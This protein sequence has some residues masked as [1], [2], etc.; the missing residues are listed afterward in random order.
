[1]NLVHRFAINI[2]VVMVGLGAASASRAQDLYDT[3]V[4]RTFDISFH[5]ADWLARLR[6]NYVSQTYILA[7][8][9]VDGTLYE[10]VG[11]RIR[12]NTSYTALPPGSQ[13]FS[14]KIKMDQVIV[15]QELMGYDTINLNNGFRDPTFTREVVYNNFVARFIPNP[16]ASHAVVT[17]NGENWGVYINVQQGDKRMLRNYFVDED[18]LRISCANNPNG[19]G[20]AYNGPGA[21]GYI[22][23]EIQS[24]GGL[25]NPLATLIALTNLLSNEPLISWPNIDTQFA[26]DPAIWS[27]VLENLLTDDDSYINKGC[28]FTAYRDPI[29]GRTHLLQRDANETFTQSTWSPTRNFNLAN[30]PVLSRVLAVP[31]LRQ[32]YFAHYR[33]AMAELSWTNFASIFAA[34]RDLIDAAVQA[35]TK[36]LYSHA[37]FQNNFSATVTLPYSG[38]AGGSLVGIEQ[39]V[40][41]RATFLAGITELAASGPSLS[42]AQALPENPRPIDAVWVTIAAA[43]NGS[44]VAAVELFYRPAPTA[45]YLRVPMLDDGISGD[46]IAGDGV[47]GVRL[48]VAA[49]PGQRV[50][51]YVG[52]TA[53]NASLSSSFMPA[54]AERGPAV[55]EYGLNASD[56]LR[57][58]EWMYAGGNGEFVELSNLSDEPINLAGWSIDDDHALPGAFPLDAAGVLQPGASVVVTDSAAEVFRA[59]WSLAADTP[60]VGL[61]GATQGNSLGRSDQINV[62]DAEGL[63]HDRLTYGDQTFTG[64]I[65]T[66]NTSGQAACSV[67]GLDAVADWQLSA[68]GDEFGSIASAAADVGTPGRVRTSD[69]GG[70]FARIFADGFE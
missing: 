25:E 52:S 62:F 70:F 56:G 41:A 2:I 40:N 59:A 53:A 69:C 63:L 8:L 37:L 39:F 17:L 28:D 29:D 47:F 12:G 6:A 68:V 18:G 15:D 60:I 48:P 34:H 38:L 45:G 30:K 49:Q 22:A 5:D 19:P 66:Q 10:D 3:S 64:T 57:I 44:S 58:T 67:F 35:D 51:W 23:Y 54:L 14:L 11:V 65:R 36:K 7:D 61:L 16:R 13:K 26:I 27:V 33:H 9:M 55:I 43:G 1:M 50:S 46:G 21:N 20:L 31:E 42:N 4:L 24:D 32:R